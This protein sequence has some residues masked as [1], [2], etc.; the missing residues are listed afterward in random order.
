MH[1][2]FAN[3]GVGNP[4]AS[5]GVLNNF[6]FQ[7]VLWFEKNERPN[8]TGQPGK[9][10]ERIVIHHVFATVGVGNPFAATETLNNL[11]FQLGL[12]LEKYARPNKTRQPGERRR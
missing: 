10:I 6:R 8:K 4:F 5:T 7:F 3:V 1:C 2:I 12:W 11:M 9:Q